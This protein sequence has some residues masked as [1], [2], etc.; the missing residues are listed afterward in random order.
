MMMMMI[1]IIIISS[2][3]SSTGFS[4]NLKKQATYS[5][6]INKKTA[7]WYD[8]KTQLTTQYR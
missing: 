5:S 7:L 3:S 6:Q 4:N 8:R 2:S 1:I